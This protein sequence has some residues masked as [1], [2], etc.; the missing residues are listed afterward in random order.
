MSGTPTNASQVDDL[1]LSVGRAE[2]TKSLIRALGMLPVLL[3]LC[4][5]FSL[6]A[7]AADDMPPN[8]GLCP[9]QDV[10]KPF[11]EAQAA[12]EGLG[13]SNTEQ[14]TDIEGDALSGTEENPVFNGNVTLRR[15]NQFMVPTN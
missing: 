13:I 10:V 6:N 4:I 15:G 7:H 9:V 1:A 2:A 11:A 8:W 5:A 12:P 3:V 14:A